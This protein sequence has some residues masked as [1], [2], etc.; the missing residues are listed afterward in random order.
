[1]SHITQKEREDLKAIC[2]SLR[3]YD[4]LSEPKRNEETGH[5]TCEIIKDEFAAQAADII[6]ELIS[7]IDKLEYELNEARNV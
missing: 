5:M 1:M 2:E 4:T 7:I 3:D 6:D